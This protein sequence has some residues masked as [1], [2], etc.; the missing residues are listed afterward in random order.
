M[1]EDPMGLATDPIYTAVY[2]QGRFCWHRS[3]DLHDDAQK[4]LQVKFKT[5]E[6]YLHFLHLAEY[7]SV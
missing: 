1:S 6:V 5:A 3:K 7:P 4:E 2:K